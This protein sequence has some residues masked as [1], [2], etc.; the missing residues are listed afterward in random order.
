MEKDRFISEQN[1]KI[2]SLTNLN[3]N[4]KKSLHDYEDML[5]GLKKTVEIMKKANNS[6]EIDIQ[7]LNITLIEQKEIID[8]KNLE[9]CELESKTVEQVNEIDML[10][11]DVLNLKEVLSGREGT[12]NENGGIIRNLS[13]ELEKKNIKIEGLVK[14]LEDKENTISNLKNS[15]NL[16]NKNLEDTNET[17]ATFKKMN[18]EGMSSKSLLLKSSE[19]FEVEN[20]EIKRKNEELNS[21][22]E[23]LLYKISIL[24]TDLTESKQKETKFYEEKETLSLHNTNLIERISLLVDENKKLYEDKNIREKAI[25]H[26]ESRFNEINNLYNQMY[27]NDIYLKTEVESLNSKLTLKDKMIENLLTTKEEINEELVSLREKLTNLTLDKTFRNDD[28]DEKISELKMNEIKFKRELEKMENELKSKEVLTESLNNLVSDFKNRLN[29][30]SKKKDSQILGL[31]RIIEDLRKENSSLKE[32]ESKLLVE[33]E[34]SRNDLKYK[35][36][37][38]DSLNNNVSEL[39]ESVISTKKEKDKINF[40]VK[41]KNEIIEDLKQQIMDLKMKN[42]DEEKKHNENLR[43]KDDYSLHYQEI[44]SKCNSYQKDYYEMKCSYE[45]LEFQYKT[46]LEKSKYKS[47]RSVKAENSPVSNK[48]LTLNKGFNTPINR[49]NNEFETKNDLSKL[50]DNPILNNVS[51]LPRLDGMRE[52]K[53]LNTFDMNLN[54]SQKYRSNRITIFDGPSLVFTIFDNKRLIKFDI[55]DR[56]FK[57][58]EFA[59]FGDYQENFVSEGS[60]NLNLKDHLFIVTGKNHNLLYHYNHLKHSMSKLADLNHNHSG[61]ALIK[62]RDYLLCLSGINTRKVEKYH[63]SDL[64]KGVFVDKKINN[65]WVE[66]TEMNNQRTLSS[67]ATINDKYLYAIFG[68]NGV[69]KQI[70]DSIERLDLEKGLQWEYINIRSEKNLPIYFYNHCSFNKDK[71]TVLIFGGIN[72]HTGKENKAFYILD[73]NSN[74]LRE[75]ETNIEK[76]ETKLLFSRNVNTIQY[77]ESQNKKFHS[78][79]FNDDFQ[80]FDVEVDGLSISKYNFDS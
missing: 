70:L 52:K 26:L 21:V 8:N 15:V 73:L 48:S 49:S 24:E 4:L 47:D 57:Y 50:E 43:N 31:E 33:L 14:I 64:F 63:N 25:S 20:I 66:F 72:G 68:F 10:K 7:N 9:I 34:D 39:N 35:T 23:G 13:S 79:I 37:L 45:K 17:V 71:E 62:H 41:E 32:T 53:P 80:I 74:S 22:K 76:D 3:E 2:I 11:Q 51:S 55:E 40:F 54:L 65:S 42:Q 29:E 19:K 5:T 46:L 67:Y 28:S 1:E 12:L 60:F 58:V 77:Q 75:T 38:V 18:N 30:T 56:K 44:I 78:I 36:K 16:L 6:N 59:D 27:S 69:T 61:G